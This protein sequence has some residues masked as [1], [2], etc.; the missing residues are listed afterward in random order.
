ARETD[1]IVVAPATADLMAKLAGGHANDLATG[2]MPAATAKILLAPA[3][4]PRMWSNKATQRNLAQL[5]AD[6]IALIGPNEGEREESNERGTRRR[7]EPLEIAAAAEK[8]L[9]ADTAQPLKGKRVLITS[10]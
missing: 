6:G 10:G 7:P 8:L 5:T 2:C 4:N 1:L 3:M 9:V